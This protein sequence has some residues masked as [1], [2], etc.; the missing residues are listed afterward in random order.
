MTHLILTHGVNRMIVFRM[1]FKLLTTCLTWVKRFPTL[2]HF[3]VTYKFFEWRSTQD[4]SLKYHQWLYETQSSWWIAPVTAVYRVNSTWGYATGG[5]FCLWDNFPYRS[6][7]ENNEYQEHGH[8]GHHIQS[9]LFFFTVTSHV[10]HGI[11][12]ITKLLV[13]ESVKLTRK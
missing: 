7:N 6:A 10:H 2:R 13:N 1:T 9:L 3:S 4:N 11:S 5:S 12:L 8:P